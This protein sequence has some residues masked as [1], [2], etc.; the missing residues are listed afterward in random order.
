MK[1]AAETKPWLSICTMP[2][3][4]PSAL[5]VKMPMVTMPMWATDE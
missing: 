5:G 4:M 3:S 2:P 1:S